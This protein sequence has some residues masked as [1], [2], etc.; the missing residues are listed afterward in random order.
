[1]WV[2]TSGSE[3]GGVPSDTSPALIRTAADRRLRRDRRVQ[4]RSVEDVS[5]RAPAV[6]FSAIVG[7]GTLTIRGIGTNE[8]MQP[9]SAAVTNAHAALRS[10]GTELPDL[11]APREAIDRIVKNGSRAS[12]VIGRLRAFSKKAPYR[13]KPWR[14]R[15]RSLTPSPT[16][17]EVVRNGISLRT[18]LADDLPPIK[19]DRVQLQQVILNLIIQRR[20][21]NQRRSGGVARVAGFEGG[22]LTGLS[23]PVTICGSRGRLAIHTPA[24]AR[25]A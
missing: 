1:V 5:G 10:L 17:C 11:G 6:T 20:R 14:S 8:T 3:A 25:H 22:I 21:G 12:D 13:K 4:S 15:T 16:R 23:G 2:P 19:A 18:K 7:F 24:F 9:I